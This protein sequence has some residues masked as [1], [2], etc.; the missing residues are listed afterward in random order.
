MRVK[1]TY[2]LEES[3]VLAVRELVEQRGLAPSQDALVE[4]AL[5]DLIT[6]ARH[7]REAALFASARDDPEFRSEVAALDQQLGPFEPSWPE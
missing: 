5:S 7:V 6:A 1:R 4:Q 3:T 2:N